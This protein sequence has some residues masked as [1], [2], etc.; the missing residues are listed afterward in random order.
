MQRCARPGSPG[1]SVQGWIRVPRPHFVGLR[2]SGSN[3]IRCRAQ[4]SPNR[5]GVGC[6]PSCQRVGYRRAGH[7]GCHG[8]SAEEFITLRP[9]LGVIEG[10]ERGL[11]R[12]CAESFEQVWKCARHPVAELLGI[13]SPYAFERLG[14]R[15]AE[16]IQDR[17]EPSSRRRL[18]VLIE[19]QTVQQRLRIGEHRVRYEHMRHP[20]LI[21][22]K[23][24][25]HVP[26]LV[27]NDVGELV[28]AKGGLNQLEVDERWRSV[29]PNEFSAAPYAFV[30]HLMRELRPTQAHS[31]RSCA[32]G[33]PPTCW[34]AGSSAGTA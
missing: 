5:G 19:P 18:P 13:H 30:V 27:S 21:S 7:G 22:G 2:R 28:S 25:F 15:G 20:K 16:C 12:V 14:L 4:R 6:W 32:R 26:H 34:V 17:V 29:D 31:R 24:R 23:A 8:N 3:R 1:P 9:S 11:N 33:S 10:V